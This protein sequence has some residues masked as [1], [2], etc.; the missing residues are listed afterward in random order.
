MYTQAELETE[1]WRPIVYRGIDYT[2]R[3]E[4][5]NLGRIRTLCYTSEPYIRQD[6]V[7]PKSGY[8]ECNL[9][10][11][12]T[13]Y[14]YTTVHR[15][16]KEVFDPVPNMD[17]L[18]VNHIDE[19]KTNNRLSNL[20]WVTS[21]ENC[22]YGSRNKRMGE[23]TSR[24]VLCL[25]TRQVFRNQ[26]E[27]AKYFNADVAAMSQHLNKKRQCV[28][29]KHF[30]RIEDYFDRAAKL[31]EDNID[32]IISQNARYINARKHYIR[33]KI[34]CVETGVV[35]NSQSEAARAVGIY[36]ASISEVLNGRAST[37][38]G[39]TWKRIQ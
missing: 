12:G 15:I 38:G 35:Y 14:H 4:V 9:P 21:K 37:A 6:V 16:V 34:L 24:P 33:S 30:V 23:K 20:E 32:Y 19:C 31:T 27:A 26:E 1:I 18:E 11:Q 10:V 25:E 5:S 2:G 29:N 28:Q 36:Q 7:N 17:K 13:K 39:Y 8:C 22:N 3:Y